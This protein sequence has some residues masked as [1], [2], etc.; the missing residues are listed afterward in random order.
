[1]GDHSYTKK[2]KKPTTK[3]SIKIDPFSSSTST[4]DYNEKFENGK[5]DLNDIVKIQFTLNERSSNLLV[6]TLMLTSS[7]TEGIIKHL[8]YETEIAVEKLTSKQQKNCFTLRK[9]DE[10]AMLSFSWQSVFN[11]FD[12]N[13]TLA[14]RMFCILCGFNKK[15]VNKKNNEKKVLK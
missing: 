10:N 11:E 15:T 7:I 1:M 4:R 12:A 14:A 8:L 9:F 3:S 2:E 5:I 6:K 13:L